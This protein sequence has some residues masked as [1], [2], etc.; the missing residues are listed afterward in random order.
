MA[1]ARIAAWVCG[2]IMLAA[3]GAVLNN[4]F[5]VGRTPKREFV[6]R[7]ERAIDLSR[8][9]L[10]VTGK[11]DNEYLLYMLRDAIR[12]SHDEKLEQTYTA[13]KRRRPG[14]WLR[15]V[16]PE[17]PFVNPGAEER[18]KLSPYH[19]WTLHAISHRSFGLSESETAEML[20]P[21][22]ARLGRATH[23]VL[24]LVLL[25]EY[26]GA[27]AKVD[28]VIDAV[29]RR[30]ATEAAIDFRVTDLYLQRIAFLLAAGHP[31]LVKPRWVERMLAAQETDGGWYWGWYGWQVT[32]YA[33]SLEDKTDGHPTIQ[34]MW[35]M[36]LL[37]SRYPEWIA[38]NYR[39]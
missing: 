15:L 9:W 2:S 26:T 32:P 31:E 8:E 23:Q 12:I 1:P 17:L 39:E 6:E 11:E 20:S 37:K 25:K 21:D 14:P 28:G 33:F 36:Y 38:A 30:I 18:K 22:R 19:L 35:A 29:C 27:D 5:S 10:L 34:A 7:L 24:A 13:V 16:D 3:G 4:N